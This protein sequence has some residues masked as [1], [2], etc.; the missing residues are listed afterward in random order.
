M[1]E[2]EGGGKWFWRWLTNAGIYKAVGRLHTPLYRVTGGL[3]G[4][5]MAGV[6]N[7]LLTTKGRRSGEPRTVALAYLDD[8]GH[9]ILIGSHGGND[10][11]PAWFLNIRANPDARIQVGADVVA[12]RARITV[13]EERSKLWAAACEMWPNYARYQTLTTREIPVV[14]LDRIEEHQ[15]A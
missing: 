7:L 13:D 15:S 10:K 2:S 9:W 4:H 11:H 6:T 12:V 1:A 8:G 14:V 5:H 3:I